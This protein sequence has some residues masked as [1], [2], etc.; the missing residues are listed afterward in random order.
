[1]K[2]SHSIGHMQPRQRR[3]HQ[4]CNGL[5]GTTN[6]YGGFSSYL[7]LKCCNILCT[8]E[9]DWLVWN[10]EKHK[11]GRILCAR[12][13]SV[14]ICATLNTEDSINFYDCQAPTIK[15]TI[16]GYSKTFSPS[17]FSSHLQIVMHFKLSPVN[18]KTFN[19]NLNSKYCVVSYS[20]CWLPREC[21]ND[22]DYLGSWKKSHVIKLQAVC[23]SG[24]SV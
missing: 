2:H 14:E 5:N 20:D 9:I 7:N 22:E 11:N 1:M 18:G 6:T 15:I 10:W 8:C 3:H 21:W 13:R 16:N 19:F 17:Y 24:T 4:C 23:Q 12:Q